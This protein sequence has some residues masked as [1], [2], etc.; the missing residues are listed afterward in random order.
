MESRREGNAQVEQFL[1]EKG[2]KVVFLS[3][4]T[5]SDIVSVKLGGGGCAIGGGVR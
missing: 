4:N 2:D 3:H 5:V 1:V